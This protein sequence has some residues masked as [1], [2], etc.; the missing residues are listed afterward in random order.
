[1]SSKGHIKVWRKLFRPQ[2][3]K[4][5]NDQKAEFA[6][7]IDLLFRYI[8]NALV[9][10]CLYATQKSDILLLQRIHDTSKN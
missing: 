8:P 10:F 1:M 2:K 3:G 6:V 9:V 5:H 7:L 4:L